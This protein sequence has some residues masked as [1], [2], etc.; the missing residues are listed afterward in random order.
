[1]LASDEPAVRFLTRRDVLA[2]GAADDEAAILDGPKVRA[3]LSGQQPDGGFGVRPYAKWAGAH[4]RL[5]SL[6][7]L[8]VPA[9]EPRAVV[10]AATVLDWLTGAGHRRGIREIDGLVRRCASQEGNALAVACRLGLAD[11]PRASLLAG[12]LVE[13]QWPDGGWNCDPRASGQRS[14]FHETLAPMW[15]LHEY[16]A[17]T[18]DDAA[19]AAAERAAELFLEHRLFRS[20]RTGGPIHPSFVAL[21]YPPYWHYDVLQALLVLSRMG[22]AGDERARDGLELLE[23]LRL[24]D[25]RW[26]PGGYWWRPPGSAGSNAEVV[27]WG[28][29]GPNELITLNALRVLARRPT[30]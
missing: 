11:D 5:V 22:L 14:S 24:D 10:A 23:R 6:V 4:W 16:A 28:R 1:L 15:G 29:N 26:R 2:E 17:A 3:L 30:A 7:E 21:H 27:D 12:S 20:T 25:G 9:G 13:W 19:R 8:G 18:G